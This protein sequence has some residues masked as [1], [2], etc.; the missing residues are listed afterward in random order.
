MGTEPVIT[1]PNLKNSKK[2][3]QSVCRRRYYFA[4]RHTNHSYMRFLLRLRSKAPN[5]GLGL[6]LVAS[7]ACSDGVGGA[8]NFVYI[9]PLFTIA[10]ATNAVTSGPIA[11]VRISAVR[12]GNTAVP[13]TY[14]SEVP[15]AHDVTVEG[16]QLV[17]AIDCGFAATPGTYTFTVS[18]A[19]YRDTVVT[20]AA[21]Y[22]RSEDSCP[23][24]VS[25]GLQLNLTLSPL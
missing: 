12:V 13:V 21:N 17:C 18:S 10:S 4:S 14:L 25:G 8:C 15:V 7:V 6:T 20:M 11:E 1:A 24:R 2:R 23:V 16:D 19:G 5:A 3:A 22:S 9:D